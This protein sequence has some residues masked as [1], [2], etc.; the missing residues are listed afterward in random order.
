M[1]AFKVHFLAIETPTHVRSTRQRE[2]NR[3]EALSHAATIAHRWAGRGLYPTHDDDEE[4][5][6]AGTGTGTYSDRR[7]V[8]RSQRSSSYRGKNVQRRQRQIASSVLQVKTGPLDPFLQLPIDLGS[9]DRQ[10]LHICEWW[11]SCN[12]TKVT[13]LLMNIEKT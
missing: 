1:A 2:L 7:E 10:L 6:V 5:K 8:R 3:A 12:V 13:I 11:N 4:R 9:E